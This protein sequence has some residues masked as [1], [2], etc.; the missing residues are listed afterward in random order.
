M[1]DTSDSQTVSVH[2]TVSVSE[3]V[4]NIKYAYLAVKKN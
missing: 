1:Q 2:G 4:Q 3:F